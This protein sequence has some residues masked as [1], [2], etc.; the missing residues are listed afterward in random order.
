MFL[1]FV[2]LVVILGFALVYAFAIVLAMALVL[3]LALILVL[4]DIMIKPEP[5]TFDLCTLTIDP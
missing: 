5:L 3:T 4:V 2:W 1:G